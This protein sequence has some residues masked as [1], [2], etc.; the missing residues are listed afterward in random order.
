MY[1]F[2]SSQNDIW[3]EDANY[4]DKTKIITSVLITHRRN[5]IVVLLKLLPSRAFSV[6]GRSAGPHA[7]KMVA[8]ID[9]HYN[10]GGSVPSKGIHHVRS[11]ILW[12]RVKNVHCFWDIDFC[13]KGIKFWIKCQNSKNRVRNQIVRN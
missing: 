9:F 7:T 4:Y 10:L 5:K 8:V 1:N 2:Q 13:K 3:I 6:D 12:E 11:Q